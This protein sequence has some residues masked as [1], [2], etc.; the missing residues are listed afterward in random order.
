MGQRDIRTEQQRENRSL[1]WG[2]T[3]R[4][5]REGNFSITALPGSYRLVAPGDASD[6]ADSL[7]AG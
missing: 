6:Y 1:G 5:D 7:I 3:A 2:S 4:T